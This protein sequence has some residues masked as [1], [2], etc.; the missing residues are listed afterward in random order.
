[1]ILEF[2]RV[3]GS[4]DSNFSAN[5]PVRIETDVFWDVMSK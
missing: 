4:T 3:N 5:K 1:M 2:E